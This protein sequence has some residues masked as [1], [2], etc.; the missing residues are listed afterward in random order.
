LDQ[1][2][3]NQELVRLVD[4]QFFERPWCGP[5]QAA[6][7]LQRPNRKNSKSI[8]LDSSL[9]HTILAERAWRNSKENISIAVL[10]SENWLKALGIS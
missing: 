3:A 5:R 9:R 4:E 6:R 7:L 2:S 10:A 1:D 8:A